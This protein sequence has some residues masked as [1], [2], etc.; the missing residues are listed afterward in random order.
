[1]TAAVPVSLPATEALASFD[2]LPDGVLVVDAAG[3]VLQANLAFLALI[4]RSHAEVV[5]RRMEALV[6]EE[7]MLHLAGFEA[8][9]H[10]GPVQD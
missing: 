6:A 10:A 7:D 1:M 2:D 8:L 4:D 3:R 5:G 9:F